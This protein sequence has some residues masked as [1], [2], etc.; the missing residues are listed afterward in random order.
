MLFYK[1]HLHF[2]AFILLCASETCT[3]VYLN[4][5]KGS[6]SCWKSR[7][8]YQ[9]FF[10]SFFLL[11]LFIWLVDWFCCCCCCCLLLFLF[12][13]QISHNSNWLWTWHV[14][15]D[16]VELLI[17]T[18][19]RLDYGYTLL[20]LA[21]RSGLF[22]LRSISYPFLL[23]LHKSPRDHSPSFQPISLSL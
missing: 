13:D 4:S 21:Q 9:P 15:K 6:A 22:H 10:L 17:S 23:C 5:G 12:W 11:F 18:F 20:S 1:Y 14:A 16:A 19:E 3:C 7:S 8:E 2:F